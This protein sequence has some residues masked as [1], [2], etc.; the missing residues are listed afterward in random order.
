TGF[1][2]AVRVAGSTVQTAGLVPAAINARQGNAICCWAFTFTDPA[3][4]LPSVI[5]AGGS[6]I[7]TL[8]R[9]VEL[10]ASTAGETSRTWP[11]AVTPASE[12]SVNE[13]L[14]RSAVPRK[15]DS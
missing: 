3:T 12:T 10:L 13:T 9:M 8:T 14:L 15:M 7:A 6:L 2:E 5:A 4:G 11:L 1:S